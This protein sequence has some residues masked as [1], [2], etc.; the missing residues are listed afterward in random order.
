MRK[1]PG[2]VYDKCAL[3]KENSGFAAPTLGWHISTFRGY[4]I[5]FS[6]RHPYINRFANYLS[7]AAKIIQTLNRDIFIKLDK[8][9]RN[10]NALVVKNRPLSDYEWMCEY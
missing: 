4:Q 8:M 10:C 1:G 7:S 6:I 9:F 2:S 3:H 5:L